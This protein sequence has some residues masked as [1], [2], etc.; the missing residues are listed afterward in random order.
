[1]AVM[2][3][4][5][6]SEQVSRLSNP[7]R[8]DAFVRRFREAVRTG[9]LE[10]A[11]GGPRFPL[12][13]TFRRRGSGETATRE[14][15]EMVIALTPEYEAWFTRVDAELAAPSRRARPKPTVENIEAGVVDFKALAEETRRKM[16][17]AYDKGQQLGKSR[18]QKTK[19]KG[20]KPARGRT[21]RTKK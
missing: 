5:T 15:R 4:T 19:G 7:Q 12:P 1:M 13:K 14:A 16:Q 9:E 6:L 17:A 20:G 18:A 10:A 2:P 11:Q 3:Y 8:S 21:T